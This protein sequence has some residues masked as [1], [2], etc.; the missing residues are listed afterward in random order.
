MKKLVTY[1]I[2]INFI[3]IILLSIF[4]WLFTTPNVI[5]IEE[6]I[7][8]TSYTA[9]FNT[10]NIDYFYVNIIERRTC[11][12]IR[13]IDTAHNLLKSGKIKVRKIDRMYI[14]NILDLEPNTE[15]EYV[16]MIPSENIERKF[17]TGDFDE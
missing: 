10:R 17:K 5:L 6:K 15:Y 9:I 13:Y 11:R 12:G 3:G 4:F 16:L 7:T 2:L 14:V 8:E 1:L